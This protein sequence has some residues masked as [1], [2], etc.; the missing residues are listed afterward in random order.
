MKRLDEIVNELRDLNQRQGV[1]EEA[2]VTLIKR[3]RDR[4]RRSTLCQTPS[5]ARE[6]LKAWVENNREQLEPHRDGRLL[7]DPQALY[8]GIRQTGYQVYPTMAAFA[9]EGLIRIDNK[10][11]RGIPVTRRTIMYKLEGIG[12]RVVAINPGALQ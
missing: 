5:D 11:E 8:K 4:P 1:T 7:A 2:L 3:L 10:V 9:N 12:R 6:W